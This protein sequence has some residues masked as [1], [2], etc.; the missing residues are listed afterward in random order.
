MYEQLDIYSFIQEQKEEPPMLLSK[1]QEVY[2]VNKA[3]V[4]K[5]TVTDEDSW[6]CGENDRGYRLIKES[7]TYDITWNSRILN[8]EAFTDCE[9]ARIKADKYLNTHDGII[10]AKDIKPISVV[11]YSYIRDCDNKELTAFYCD[12]GNDTYYIKEFMTFHHICKGKKAIKDFMRQ[13]EFTYDNTKQIEGFM[14]TFQNM[15]RCTGTTDW[16]YAEAEYAK[17]VG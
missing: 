9:A 1:G 17:A 7:G 3:E 13:Q 8:E 4:I 12:L 5:C 2:L 10:L 11:A 14:P 15:Y 16:E 6:L